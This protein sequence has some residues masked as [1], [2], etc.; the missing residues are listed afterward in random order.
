MKIFLQSNTEK[1]S[2]WKTIVLKAGE[3]FKNQQAVDEVIDQLIELQADRQ[4]FIVGVG[5]GVVTDIAGFAASIYMR[6]IK[7]WFCSDKYSCNGRCEYWWKKWCR[8]WRL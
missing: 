5:G 3:Q 4:T 1:F 7:V 2:G 8:C 6:G